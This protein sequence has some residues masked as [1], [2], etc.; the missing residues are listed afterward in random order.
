MLR[1]HFRVVGWFIPIAAALVCNMGATPA[2][3]KPV[4]F[5][6]FP[7][8]VAGAENAA[9]MAVRQAT[10]QSKSAT[11]D[12]SQS[13]HIVQ[14]GRK[15]AT[16]VAGKVQAPGAVYVGCFMALVQDG[17]TTVVPTIGSGDWEAETCGRAISMGLI[18]TRNGVII[19]IVYEA[20]SPNTLVREP[21]LLRWNRKDRTLVADEAL[22]RQASIK[23]ATTIAAMGRLLK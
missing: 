18:A 16:L 13:F 7:H 23:G 1:R 11:I 14:Q 5:P 15:V 3:A 8:L 2:V 17:R 19:G 20:S 10:R 6:S 22:S 4:R 12:R 21:V 9:I